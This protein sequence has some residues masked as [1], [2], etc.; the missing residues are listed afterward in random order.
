MT[1]SETEP[2]LSADEQYQQSLTYGLIIST[3]LLSIVICSL[4]LYARAFILKRFGTDDIAVCISLVITQSFNGLGIAIVYYGEGRHFDNLSL[5]NKAIWLKVLSPFLLFSPWM[6]WL[7][8]GLMIFQILFSFSGSIVLATQCDPPRAAFDMT[9]TN[10]TCYSQFK[11][12]QIVL[13][14]AVLIFVS[15]VIILLAPM[16]ILC[17]LNMPT[18][19]IVALVAI[20]GTG[21]IACI[22]PVVRFSTLDYLRIGTTDLTYDSASSLYWMAIEFNL[23]LVAGSLSSLKPLPVFRRFGS[24]AESN[25]ASTGCTPHELGAMSGSDIKHVR[26]KS[27]SLGMG[28]TILAE[29]VNESQERIFPAA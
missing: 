10:A 22:A 23:G 6:N 27:H 26:N 11:L 18:R 13:Y 20:F 8:A 9:V 24:S 16:P 2:S 5:E 21:I 4:R 12:F 1:T 28:T 29:S 14:Q 7:T 25:K 19:K 3:G 15:D 17:Q